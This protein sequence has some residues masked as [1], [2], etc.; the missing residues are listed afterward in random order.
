MSREGTCV[1]LPV[2]IHPIFQ[3]FLGGTTLLLLSGSQE[4]E[5]RA[6]PISTVQPVGLVV[7]SGVGIDFRQSNE[8]PSHFYWT[9]WKRQIFVLV[10]CFFLL[11]CWENRLEAWGSWWPSCH[12]LG[13]ASMGKRSTGRKAGL[14]D[15]RA[16]HILGCHLS[17]WVKLCL[18]FCYL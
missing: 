13:R 1:V 2:R 14:R 5:T 16:N 11:G 12:D 17:S 8:I 3:I 10:G 15:G 6:W 18:I 9:S 7:R 4:G